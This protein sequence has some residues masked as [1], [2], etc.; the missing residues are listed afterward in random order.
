MDPTKELLM[1][2]EC[3]APREIIWKA[4]TDPDL[5]K[6]W[7]GPD[8]VT[9]PTAEFDARVGGKIYIVMLAGPELGPMK[10]Q[11]WPMS[12]TIK[13]LIAP[14]R[15]V[16]TSA[17]I[18]EPSGTTLLENLVTVT[19]ADMGGETT[20]TVHVVVTMSTE[21]AAAALAGMQMGWNQQLD[22]LVKLM[23]TR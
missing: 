11:K 1:M 14:E 18:D 16:F 4:W 19:L 3:D 22:K 12:A 13:E 8:G 5:I 17:A 15:L 10:G 2:R 7:W 20:M 6:Q 21:K 23:A 9:I